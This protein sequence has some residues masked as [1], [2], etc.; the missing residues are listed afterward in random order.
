MLA[1]AEYPP[2]PACI[3]FAFFLETFGFAQ[4]LLVMYMAV[5]AMSLVVFGRKIS[6]GTYDW[7]LL[8]FTLG[9]PLTIGVVGAAVP[10]WGPSGTW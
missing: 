9:I 10:F 2:D 8:V 5:S 7:R 1:K 3:T 4:T 6:L